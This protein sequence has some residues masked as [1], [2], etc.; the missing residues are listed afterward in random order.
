MA[1]GRPMTTNPEKLAIKT[2]VK[3]SA[4]GVKIY[5]YHRKTGRPIKG[6]PGT[7]EFDRSFLEAERPNPKATP[8][9][10]KL[11]DLFH[12]YRRS[13]E[14]LGLAERTR[15]RWGRILDRIEDDLPWVVVEDLNGEKIIPD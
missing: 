4:A 9:K 14:W 8:P 15:Y 10:D 13:P 2:V 1:E 3:R 11:R 5:R 7:P 6:E 12:R